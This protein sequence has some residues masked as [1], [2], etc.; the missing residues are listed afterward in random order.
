VADKFPVIVKIALPPRKQYQSGASLIV[1]GESVG[2]VE[3]TLDEL[4]GTEGNGKVILAAFAQEALEGGVETVLSKPTTT[5]A[6]AQAPAAEND[7]DEDP[8]AS[9][10]LLKV[11]AKKTGADLDALKAEGLTTSAA[12]TRLKEAK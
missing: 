3:K 12:K 4:C 7:G 8:P 9:D 2:D 6:P 1:Q 10:N 11:L 5:A